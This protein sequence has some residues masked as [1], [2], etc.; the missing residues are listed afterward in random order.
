MYSYP[1]WPE[2]SP[3][4]WDAVA[5]A[6]A[7][8]EAAAKQ[9]TA[10]V[11]PQLAKVLAAFQAEKL[12][13]HHF[14]SVN[15]Y[16]HNDQGR[17]TLDRVFA[18]VLGAE[19]AAV[20]LQFVSGTHAIAA[21]LFGVLRPG[22]RLLSI[23]GRPY[24]TLEEVIGIRGSGQGSLAEFGIQYSELPLT[25][26]GHV[27]ELG[28][29]DALSQ[30]TR[31]V[32]IQRSCGYSWRPSLSVAQIGRLVEQLKTIQPG[33][34]VFVDNC[35]GE[36]VEFEEPTAVGADL[37]AGSLIKNLGGTIVP[38]GAYVAG[39]AELVEQACCRLTAPGIGSAG[40]SGFDLHRLLFQGLFLAP[41]M[42]AEALINADLI[43][44]VF[45]NQA[46][47]VQPLA[48]AARSDVIQAVKFGDPRALQVVCNAFQ[49][50]SPVES[51]LKPVPAPMPGY[52]SELLMAGGSF[53]DGSTSE[54]SADA[55]L[56]EPYVLF[57]QGGTH[58]SHGALA[59]AAALTS[60]WALAPN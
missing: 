38:S 56:R 42:V 6:Q 44:Q 34:L 4:A 12:G 20:R 45:S 36:L 5:A 22:D 55:P 53:I 58:R 13:S 8:L 3:A 14:A 54:F 35:Y 25:G 26:Q 41:Q 39:V 11:Q 47:E 24:D 18:R 32:L 29:S 21:A 10:A 33:V 43:A 40:G 46:L 9:R 16:G 60:W 37:I 31:M 23:T 48:G 15:G 7:Q 30:P 17:D 19:R 28:L 57:S 50:C 59:L 52:A 27:D 51:Y 49:S 1:T 2:A